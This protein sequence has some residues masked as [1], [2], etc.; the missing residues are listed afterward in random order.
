[1]VL[2]FASVIKLWKLFLNYG[3]L[4]QIMQDQLWNVGFEF[5]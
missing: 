2:K 3:N 4:K 5:T 1:M